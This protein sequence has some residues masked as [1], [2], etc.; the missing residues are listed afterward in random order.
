MAKM[1]MIEAIQNAHDVMMERDERIIVFGEDV[2]FSL[3]CWFAGKIWT[4][5]LF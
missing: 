1:T 4:N 5:A 3:H 2:G